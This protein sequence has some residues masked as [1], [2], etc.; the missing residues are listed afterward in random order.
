[1]FGL[2]KILLLFLVMFKAYLCFF[3][4]F[5]QN[6]NLFSHILHHTV[7]TWFIQHRQPAQVHHLRGHVFTALKFHRLG[8]VQHHILL[9]HTH[10]ILVQNMIQL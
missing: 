2:I 1:M 4:L 3:L 5:A 8:I 6:V 9:V 10:Q 7:H